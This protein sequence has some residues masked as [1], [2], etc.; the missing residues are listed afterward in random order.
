MIH[1]ADTKVERG[2]GN[3]FIRQIIKF[4]EVQCC[5]FFIYCQNSSSILLATQVKLHSQWNM[6]TI[7]YFS[8]TLYLFLSFSLVK[9]LILNATDA[10]GVSC[11]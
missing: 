9:L 4:E 8:V 11:P 3:F 5:F 7:D 1:I 2:Y 6:S 10:N